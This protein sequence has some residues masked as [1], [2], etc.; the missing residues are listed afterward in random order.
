MLRILVF[1]L[2]FFFPAASFRVL[3]DY[4]AQMR[5]DEAEKLKAN[6]ETAERAGGD[7]ILRLADGKTFTQSN[8][9]QC[10]FDGKP[11]VYEH[12]IDYVF[13]DH[14]TAHRAFLVKVWNQEGNYYKWIDDRT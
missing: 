14:F 9:T 10:G 13:I 3:A 7:L 11:F 6:R 5:I 4:I 2:V 8:E 12:C 1:S